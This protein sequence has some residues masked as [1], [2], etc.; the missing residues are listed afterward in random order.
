MISLFCGDR[1]SETGKGLG[2]HDRTKPSTCTSVPSKCGETKLTAPK[3]K[4]SC[5]TKT[6]GNG[7]SPA[8]HMTLLLSTLTHLTLF[9]IMAVSLHDKL[10]FSFTYLNATCWHCLIQLIRQMTET[11]SVLFVWNSIYFE[12]FYVIVIF[13][14]LVV[15]VFGYLIKDL[16]MI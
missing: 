3:I 15:I 14:S 1:N 7:I 9:C 5:T 2:V 8:T 6:D 12:F 16:N 10:H 13:F 11:C 4:V